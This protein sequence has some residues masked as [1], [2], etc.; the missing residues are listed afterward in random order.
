MMSEK[1]KI[2]VVDDNPINL[3]VLVEA[4]DGK[5]DVALAEDGSVA[6]AMAPAF[7]PDVVLL[8]VMMP[9]RDG[10]DV[11]RAI[12]FSRELRQTRIIMVSARADLASRLK[13]YNAGADDYITKPFDEEELLTKVLFALRT[14]R[15][16]SLCGATGEVLALL[17]ELRDT[18]CDPHMEAVRLVSQQVATELRGTAGM[19]KI[20]DQFIDDLHQ[21]SV[22]RDV[23]MLSIPEALRL[24]RGKWTIDE[25]EHVKQH[26]LIGASLLNRLADEHAGVSLLRMA[27]D[28]A[29][30]HHEQF[31]GR[32]Y[33]DRL[34][35]DDIPLAARIVHAAE[36]LVAGECAD[37]TCDPRIAAVLERVCAKLQ[38]AADA[39]DELVMAS[40]APALG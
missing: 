37:V 13:G 16:S 19:D 38:S 24:R 4:L 12:K 23:G 6:L 9:G 22:L 29:R 25:L 26:T 17:S 27:A 3:E 35:G 32:G 11:C 21:A 40:E 2:M 1:A 36:A 39:D 15:L 5:F 8:D 30:S 7:Q 31:D 20:N 18:E 33:P 28:V 14:K 10:F 34:A